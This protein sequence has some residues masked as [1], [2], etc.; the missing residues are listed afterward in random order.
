MKMVFLSLVLLLVITKGLVSGAAITRKMM[1][2]ED[3][4]YTAARVQH[5]MEKGEAVAKTSATDS[6]LDINNHHAIPRPS[7]DSSQNHGP[8]DNQSSG[9]GSV[10]MIH[11]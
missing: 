3:K 8:D 11:S 10:D 7:W 2:P 6:K 4:P 1:V 5:N 9:G